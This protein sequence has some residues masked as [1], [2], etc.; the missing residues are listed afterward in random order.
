M[1]GCVVVAAAALVTLLAGCDP[2]GPAPGGGIQVAE[3]IEVVDYH[4]ACGNEVL[5]LPDGRRFYPFVDQNE[6]DEDAY[7][8]APTPRAV[9]VP[10]AAATLAVPAPQPGDDSGTLIIYEDGTAHF[11]SETGTEAWLTGEEQTYD[12]VC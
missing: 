3:T 8:G 11:V 1:R 12:W 6:V 2:N 7:A 9:A 5:E 10:L 4:Y